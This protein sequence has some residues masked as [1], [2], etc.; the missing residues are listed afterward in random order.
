MQEQARLKREERSREAELRQQEREKLRAEKAEQFQQE[1]EL[2]ES[3]RAERAQQLKEERER[4]EKVRAEVRERAEKVRAEERKK[5]EK[6][7]AE[8]RKKAEKARAEAE[9]VRSEERE[10]REKVR[11]EQS[12]QRRRELE[13]AR[14]AMQSRAGEVL[15]GTGKVLAVGAKIGGLFA[16]I[17]GDLVW[18]LGKGTINAAKQAKL[19]TS[20]P[21]SPTAAAYSAVDRL[22]D[23]RAKERA[24]EAKRRMVRAEK[25]AAELQEAA[26]IEGLLS[27]ESEDLEKLSREELRSGSRKVRADMENMEREMVALEEEAA[28]SQQEEQV[29]EV[30]LDVLR[31]AKE[32]VEGVEVELLVEAAESELPEDNH[33]W[34]S[35]YANLLRSA[36]D[37]EAPV[38][39]ASSSEEEAPA[40]SA[41]APE[42][43]AEAPKSEEATDVGSYW[44]NYYLDLKRGGSPLPAAS[45][46]EGE[47]GAPAASK[48]GDPPREEENVEAAITAAEGA[49]EQLTEQLETVVQAMQDG[50]QAL[51]ENADGGT[52]RLHADHVPASCSGDGQNPAESLSD[53]LE[54]GLRAHTEN[55]AGKGDGP[56]GSLDKSGGVF[57]LGF[58]NTSGGKGF[59]SGRPLKKKSKK[60]KKKVPTNTHKASE[61]N[62][63]GTPRAKA[64][65]AAAESLSEADRGALA[66]ARNSDRLR[67]QAEYDRI[68]QR[69]EKMEAMLLEKEAQLKEM[70]SQRTR[71]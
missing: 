8:E 4:A 22:R 63:S 41:T 62:L 35:Y 31:A 44:D 38:D 5:A 28:A 54:E 34:D 1:R 15:S 30:V 17:G 11:A 12:E 36:P 47:A 49:N 43:E 57:R 53:V 19:P 52:E 66:S 61:T 50:V 58:E 2:R 29:E 65:A 7:R 64:A 45:P 42:V 18:E 46:L 25:L 13:D 3:A 55:A 24:A 48:G 56:A 27:M 69:M 26:E 20:L 9:K 60:K 16:K 67:M 37:S 59:G 71:R 21:P 70:A 10:K 23:F 68:K 39:A 33:S 32:E 51:A 6:A 14:A 40:A